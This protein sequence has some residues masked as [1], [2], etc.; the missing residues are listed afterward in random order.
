MSGDSAQFSAITLTGFTCILKFQATIL[1]VT[2]NKVRV[3]R[4]QIHEKQVYD[5]MQ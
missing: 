1:P 2:G 4:A 5:A 3:L